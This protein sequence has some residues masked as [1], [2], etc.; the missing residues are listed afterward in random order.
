MDPR[1]HCSDSMAELSTNLEAFSLATHDA[2][3]PNSKWNG[4]RLSADSLILDFTTALILEGS[5]DPEFRSEIATL[6][7]QVVDIMPADVDPR[8]VELIQNH[9]ADVLLATAEDT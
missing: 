6:L 7:Q 1:Q 4:L 8:V 9:I 5:V 3:N 2:S